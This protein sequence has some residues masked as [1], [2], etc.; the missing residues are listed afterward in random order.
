[1]ISILLFAGLVIVLSLAM[2]ALLQ[3]VR[4]QRGLCKECGAKDSYIC[5]RCGRYK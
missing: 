4:D 2:A 1:M 3:F 5:N